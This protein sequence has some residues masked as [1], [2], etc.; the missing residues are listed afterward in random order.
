MARVLLS[1]YYGFSNAGDEAILYSIVQAFKALAPDLEIIV[2]SHDPCATEKWLPVTA[3]NRWRP[4]E[5]ARAL[6]RADL[7]I[8]GGGSLFQDVTGAKSLLY[9][10]GVL[11][12]ARILGRPRMIYAQG[13]GPLQR[14]W[15]RRLTAR[16]LDCVQLITLR[17]SYS[18]A[19]LQ[20]LG[21]QRPV[22]KVTA[23]PVLGMDIGSLDLKAGRNK[24]LQ[25]GLEEGRRPMAGI[26]LRSWPHVE[27]VIEAL[28]R[29]GD[30]LVGQG[31]EV[32]FLPFHFP[33]DVDACYQVQ[34][35]MQAPAA[36]IKEKL[37]LEELAGI[38]SC[39]DLL[40]GMRLH[41]LILA[42]VF[43]VPFLGL[44]YDPKVEA[45]C[46]QVDQPWVGLN[47][48]DFDQLWSK[49]KKMIYELPYLKENIQRA[50]A[51]LRPLARCNAELALKLLFGGEI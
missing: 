3:V 6:R 16:A 36:I 17:D 2:L 9:Y 51:E 19:F 28:A 23:D 42:A 31:W 41:A 48:P 46:R 8:S 18:R 30:E 34:R 4:G 37:T 5:V 50:V 26:A 39:L 47:F 1:G 45:F 49:I 20:S 43:K 10:L 15:A 12:M 14:N 24:L 22:I 7:F 11:E 13:L 21:V 32:V 44:S 27:G 33:R 25:L 35:L 38:I 29:V 40:L